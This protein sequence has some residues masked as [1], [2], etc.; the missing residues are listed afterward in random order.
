MKKCSRCGNLSDDNSQFCEV[1]GAAL[2]NE[3]PDLTPPPFSYADQ[4]G[5]QAYQQPVGQTYQQP[6][7]QFYQQPGAP[8]YQQQP[9][10]PAVSTKQEYL[11]LP[12]NKKMRR[13]I[14]GSAILCYI[15]A[16]VTLIVVVFMAQQYTSL[17]DVAIVLGLGLAIHLRQNK[18]CA[19]V[20]LVYAIINTV[21]VFST[22]GQFGGWLLLIAG[23]FAI[24]YTFKLD[25]EWKTYRQTHG[26]Q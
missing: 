6:D 24:I 3:M 11:A 7:G 1:C 13:E 17:I 12:E 26:M 5:G 8:M 25:K 21:I 18:I 22:S 2:P 14:T 16:A 4:P 20:L 19:I 23:I 15:S 9:M 10:M